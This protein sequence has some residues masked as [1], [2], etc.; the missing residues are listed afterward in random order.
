M[1]TGP[2]INTQKQTILLLFFTQRKKNFFFFFL[3]QL[4]KH[5]YRLLG[6]P[7]TKNEKKKIFF[8]HAV[9]TLSKM[10]QI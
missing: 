5:V 6:F 2:K 10:M 9:E 3:R 4:R 8:L 1:E 7:Q